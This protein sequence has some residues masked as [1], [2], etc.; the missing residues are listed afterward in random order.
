VLTPLEIR[1]EGTVV[2]KARPISGSIAEG[3]T[4]FLATL[5]PLPVG[6]KLEIAEAGEILQ[7]RVVRV[8]EGLD[9]QAAG[10]IVRAVGAS[11]AID[12]PPPPPASAEAPGAP[13]MVAPAPA[14]RAPATSPT[15]LNR[16]L[17]SFR[18]PPTPLGVPIYNRTPTPGSTPAF[19]RAPI[20][21]ARPSAPMPGRGSTP[22]GGV[23][24]PQN[25]VKGEIT[26][27]PSRPITGEINVPSRPADKPT[28]RQDDKDGVPEPIAAETSANGT[29]S[30][31]IE[32]SGLI[33]TGGST[34]E[35]P[36]IGG[37]GANKRRRSRRTR[38]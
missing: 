16:P 12:I 3:G 28:D 30:S 31:Q 14:V 13:T 32:I 4:L 20:P 11:E 17:S 25:T 2:G 7:V 15:S 38:R 23:L 36:S 35:M 33:E 37:N 19:A 5:D 9:N 26:I 29:S 24:P 1:Y 18:R 22:S 10:M 27:S 6:T 21:G 34:A 8:S